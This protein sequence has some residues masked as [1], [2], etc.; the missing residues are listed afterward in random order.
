[1]CSSANNT[2]FGLAAYFFSKD[3]ARIWRVAEAIEA[4]MIGINTGIFASET[5][6]I[7]SI[8]NGVSFGIIGGTHSSGSGTIANR[9]LFAMGSGP[10]NVRI[11]FGGNAITNPMPV[12]IYNFN[13]KKVNDNI[14]VSW[15]TAFEQNNDHFEIE[16][17]EDGI[18]FRTIEKYIK[19]SQNSNTLLKY[20][21]MDVEK[22]IS[23]VYYRIKQID[24][25]ANYSYSNVIHYVN[26]SEIEVVFS[27]NP[28]TDEL[29]IASSKNIETE[30]EVYDISGK[31]LF[32]SIYHDNLIQIN[33][34][35]FPTGVL[36]IKVNQNG[37]NTVKRVV[38]K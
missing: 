27:P 26:Q 9:T 19:G 8:D 11:Y 2:E 14:L 17:S 30:I 10:L 12:K 1:M 33:T 37:M 22:T 29:V 5:R 34:A 36:F 24:N 18:A 16:K 20:E 3:I 7:G 38:K 31:I 4:G 21:F 15:H 28:I 6:L 32:K 35:S 23:N 25:D 13:A